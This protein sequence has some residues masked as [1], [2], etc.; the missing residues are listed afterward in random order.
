MLLPLTTQTSY[1][2]RAIKRS[3]EG[4]LR[5]P[6]HFCLQKSLDY[7]LKCMEA[8]KLATNPEKAALVHFLMTMD[9]GYYK[10][11]WLC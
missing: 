9:F 3:R 1:A 11:M 7:S 4:A 2:S 10:W 6:L 5:H 8:F